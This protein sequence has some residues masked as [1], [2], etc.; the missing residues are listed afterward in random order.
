MQPAD[1]PVPPER[2]P[3]LTEVIEGAAPG[4]T[5][6]A[7]P[8]VGLP[9]DEAG[10][11]AGLVAAPGP[12]AAGPPLNEARIVSQV[13]LDL[14]RRIDLMLEYRLREAL[15][16]ALARAADQLIQEARAELAET[17]RDVVARAVAQE[18]ARHRPR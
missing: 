2:L 14:Q 8:G 10:A 13:M 16:P 18:V 1:R 3:T 6:A 4:D 5:A 11:G 7:A 17:L 12:S 9:A 15:A